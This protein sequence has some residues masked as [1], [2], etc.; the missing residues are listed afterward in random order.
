MTR[1]EH[2]HDYVYPFSEARTESPC[3]T[4][5]PLGCARHSDP[6]APLQPDGQLLDVRGNFR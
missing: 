1:R 6:A 3:N 5:F 4:D 2:R